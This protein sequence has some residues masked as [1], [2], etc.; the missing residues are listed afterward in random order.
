MFSSVKQSCWCAW[1][2]EESTTTS[3]EVTTVPVVTHLASCP[4]DRLPASRTTINKVTTKAVSAIHL[5]AKSYSFSGTRDSKVSPP[6][7]SS[8]LLPLGTSLEGDKLLPLSPTSPVDLCVPNGGKVLSPEHS[9]SPPSRTYRATNPGVP[10]LH[11]GK[12][13]NT[14]RG[15]NS[16]QLVGSHTTAGSKVIRPDR[17]R[18]TAAH[19]SCTS[20][21]FISCQFLLLF[22]LIG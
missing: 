6:S 5:G 11:R 15:Q 13:T 12:C 4:R 14:T 9:V 10:G 8:Q 2:E 21:S 17:R 1:Q 22:S 3:Q 7:S 20:P 19:H 18:E 16:A